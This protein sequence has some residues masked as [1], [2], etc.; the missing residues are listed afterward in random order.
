[1]CSSYFKRLCKYYVY[2]FQWENT[3]V[4][5]RS[6]RHRRPGLRRFLKFLVIF[7]LVMKIAYLRRGVHVRDVELLSRLTHAGIDLKWKGNNKERKNT[8]GKREHSTNLTLTSTHLS[9][10]KCDGATKPAFMVSELDRV[11]NRGDQGKVPCGGGQAVVL[12]SEALHWP[13]HL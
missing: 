7:W 2:N 10:K 8:Y 5:P 13:V 11:P 4:H 3:L 1:M 12:W 9:W 6:R